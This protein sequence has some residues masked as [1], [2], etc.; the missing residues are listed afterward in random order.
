M[1]Q[2][3]WDQSGQRVYE[4]GVDRGV[5]YSPDATGAY[6]TG[7][8]WNGLVTV[9]E[10]PS[11]A[12]SNPQYADN[13]KY[14]NLVSAEEFGATVEAFT[15][16][17]EFAKYDGS[18]SLATGVI[19][20]QQNRTPFGLAYRTKLGN[21]LQGTDFG[22]K[23]HLIYGAQ[24]NP[25]ERAYTTVNDSPEAITF[26][27]ELSTTAVP[28]PGLKPSASITVDS[29]KVPAGALTALENILYGT[30]GTDP[31]LPLPSEVLGLFAG[32]VTVTAVPA[33]GTYN[34]STK[35]LTIPSQTGIDYYID[36]A[37]KT[38]TVTLTKNTVLTARPQAGY[39]FPDP[40]VDRW[41]YA[42]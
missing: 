29:T 22:Y 32:A 40:S 17:P 27:W 24:A 9:T 37:K 1:T 30:A 28:V 4:T 39:V 5:L 3:Q 2:L 10:T 20:G 18:A 23:I 8:A 12:E 34:S 6:T 33:G 16:P 25:S 21:D 14:L 15:Y 13:I 36:G 31:R 26:S 38:G 35:V 11:G 42:F 19:V 7:V 41:Y